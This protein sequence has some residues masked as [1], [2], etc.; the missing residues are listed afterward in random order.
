[1]NFKRFILSIVLVIFLIGCSDSGSD[2][3]DTNAESSDEEQSANLNE[4]GEFPIVDEQITLD[5]FAGRAPA[6]N[7]DWNDVLIFN[8]YEEMTNI[9]INWEMVPLEGLT[10]QR[11]IRLA[12][13]DLPDAFHTARFNSQDIRSYGSQGLFIPLNDLIE[14]HAPNFHSI[15]EQ[16]PEIR[17]AIT[18]PD[19]NIYAF[20]YLFDPDFTSVLTASRPWI[21]ADWLEQLGM[22]NPE[23]TEEF[24]QYLTAVKETDLNG[25]GEQDEIPFGADSMNRLKQWLY[26]AFGLQNM[27]MKHGFVDLDPA[28]SGEELRFFPIADEYRQLLEYMN[29]LYS[30][31]LIEE[32]IYSIEPTQFFANGAEGLYGST[33]YYSPDM[34]FSEEEGS[35][36]IGANALEGPNGVRQYTSISSPVFNPGA[37]VIT[38][39]NEHPEAT[40]RWVDYFYGEE[41]M[42]LFFTGVEGVTYE[43]DE[44][45]NKEFI[46]G[47]TEEELSEY[48]TYPGGF[49]PSFVTSEYFNGAE[50]TEMSWEAVEGLEPYMIEKVY[51]EFIFT[52]DEAKV[53]DT[54][55]ADIQKY[56]NEMADQFITG[57]VPFSEWDNYVDTINGMNLEE[58]MNVQQAAFDR[59]EETE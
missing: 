13:G 48:L 58:Y 9:D 26:G 38:S 54:T 25:N 39:E 52:E 19:G 10:E 45:G 34:T 31:G 4:E 36:F 44:E 41:G 8:E 7:N 23:T 28:G 6:S 35:K 57:Q 18:M 30:E 3:E 15:L 14:E 32:N 11:N 43:L 50:N 46:V 17:Q 53:M 56:V 51:P 16:H 59:L 29:K 49:Y 27:G 5:F 47:T 20:P 42:E 40:V 55:G 1:M 33:D 24:Y 12:S 37:F 2:T 22:D 21:R